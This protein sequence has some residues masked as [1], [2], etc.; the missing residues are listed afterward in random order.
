MKNLLRLSLVC[1]ALA[2]MLVPAAPARAQQKG[3]MQ[4]G[5]AARYAWPGMDMQSL[6]PAPGYGVVFHYFLTSTTSIDAG[7]DYL[8][9]TKSIDAPGS[10]VDLDYT[11][12]ALSMGLRYRPKVDFVVRPFVEGGVGYEFWTTKIDVS[13]SENGSGN[14]VVYY[15]GLGFDWE[16][17]E[18]W[19]LSGGARYL[20]L[21]Q[22]GKLESE[23]VA[24]TGGKQQVN[25][26]DLNNGALTTVGIE[27]TWR[28]K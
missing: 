15:G 6:G 17:V 16:F 11:Q 18:D 26:D 24:G 23:V 9:L 7:F 8:A 13:G 20:Y 12:W 2:A 28:F 14:S 10:N 3:A 19:T 25:Y 1:L 27:L 22:T 21:P 5:L 4:I